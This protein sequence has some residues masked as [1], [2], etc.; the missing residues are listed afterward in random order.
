[1]PKLGEWLEADGFGGF[2][3]STVNGI[4]TRRYHALVL[5]ATTPPTGR[6]VLVHGFDAWVE[7]PRG[8]FAI[9]SQR[10]TPGVTFPDGASRL[11][12]FERGPW[13]K[14][15]YRLPD[16]TRA[17]VELFVPRGRPLAAVRFRREGGGARLVLRPFVSGRDHHALHHENPHLDPRAIID[18]GFVTWR[19]YDGVPAIGSFASADYT[20]EPVWYR[21]F[22]Y[23]E[24]AARGLDAV[25]DAWS[26]GTLTFD[27]RGDAAW[28]VGESSAVASLRTSG[29]SPSDTFE[30]LAAGESARRRLF[31]GPLERSADAY[32]VRRGEGVS[33]IAGYP[34]FADWGRDTFIAMRGLCLAT[35]RFDEARSILLEWAGAVSRG[36]LPNRFPEDGSAPEYNAVDASLWFVVVVGELFDLARAGLVHLEPKDEATLRD[37]V[38]AILTGYADG[39]QHGIRLDDDGLIAAGEPGVQ[40]TWMDAKVGDRV[41]TP[42]IGK[43][44][45]VQALWLNA[46]D[47]GARFDGFWARVQEKGAA[48]FHARFW[49]PESNAL[50]DVVDVDHERGKNDASFRPNQIFAV[51]GLP[52]VLLSP[53]RARR[54]V[55]AVESRLWTPM[56]LRSLAVGE[57]GYRARY[58]GGPAQR[59]GAYH[60][61]TVWP[62]LAGP[63][64]EAWV[65]V[66]GDT[67]EA[68]RGARARFLGPLVRHIDDEAGLGH[69]S[70]I[71]DAEPPHTPRGCPFQAWSLAEL[72]RLDRAVLALR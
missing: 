34:W 54:V 63:F 72:I 69:A 28:I 59:D 36:M 45:E 29:E 62:W 27:L 26:P 9:T 57:P 33:V 20:H 6:R 41:V 37:A 35:G 46:L 5:V 55:Q 13:P 42:R 24:E 51:G 4:R 10:Y 7:T 39:T 61:G 53:E 25:E 23:A 40:L 38:R 32:I 21:N 22:F 15:S 43:P 71:A 56:G 19:P 30:R 48:S 14:W 60:Q 64:V 2:A 11:E 47:V 16:G 66:H 65:R 44:V 49:N 67:P 58:E 8:R 1:M 31:A 70:E 68:R 12:S 17:T 50:F 18:G 3:S 52:R